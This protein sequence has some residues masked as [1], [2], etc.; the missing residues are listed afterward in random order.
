CLDRAAGAAERDEYTGEFQG[1]VDGVRSHYANGRDEPVGAAGLGQDR[2]LPFAIGDAISG[3][4]RP[5]DE[6]VPESSGF[7]THGCADR[8]AEPGGGWD[9]FDVATDGRPASQGTRR[10]VE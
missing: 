6:R 8:G 5:G 10:P 9:R 4:L 2:R 3:E 7:Q 1:G